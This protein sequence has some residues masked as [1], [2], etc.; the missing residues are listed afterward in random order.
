MDHNIIY[1]LVIITKRTKFFFLREG[2]A[3]QA[4]AVKATFSK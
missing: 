1:Q 2:L 4:T 3:A